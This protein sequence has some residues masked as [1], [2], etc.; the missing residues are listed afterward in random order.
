MKQSI[1]LALAV[2]L[3]LIIGVAADRALS[4]LDYDVRIGGAGQDSVVLKLNRRTGQTWAVRAAVW[5]PIRDSDE[6]L[7]K[8][9]RE[10]RSSVFD[11][12]K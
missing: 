4:P 5:R 10:K 1:Q 7:D 9:K 11:Y 8:E 2:V 6:P 3:G 12:T